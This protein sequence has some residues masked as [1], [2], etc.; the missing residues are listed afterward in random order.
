[1]KEP[2]EEYKPIEKLELKGFQKELPKVFKKINCPSCA[3]EVTADNL[4]LQ[5]SVAKCGNCN[6]IFSI[7]E[8]VEKV[9]TKKEM[10]Q[11]IFRPEGIDLFSFRDDLEITV[12]QHLQGI[13]AFGI[14]VFPAFAFFA[15]M[16]SLIHI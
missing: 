8:E 10:K 6:V 3:K 5:N 14:I 16:L 1:M 15:I 2:I 4:N 11:E 12:Q 7:E 9:K 13:N